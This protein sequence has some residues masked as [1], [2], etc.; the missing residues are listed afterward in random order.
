MLPDAAGR[1]AQLPLTGGSSMISE[2][3]MEVVTW[4]RPCSWHSRISAMAASYFSRVVLYTRS[5]LV[6]AL[7]GAIGRDDEL[8]PGAVDFLEF[9][10]FCVRRAGHATQLGVEA[11]VVLEVIDARVWFSAWMFTFLGLDGL[12]QAIAPWQ[13][14]SGL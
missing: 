12:V 4:C 3:S 5:K 6:V 10:G 8:V 7:A 9:V 11:E 13:P 14:S 1:G 2:F